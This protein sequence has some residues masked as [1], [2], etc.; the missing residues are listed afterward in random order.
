MDERKSLADANK[1]DDSK[2]DENS[3]MPQEEASEQEIENLKE[4]IEK[5]KQEQNKILAA[6][7]KEGKL[8]HSDI[9]K[10]QKLEKHDSEIVQKVNELKEQTKQEA[11]EAHVPPQKQGKGSRFAK[12]ITKLK[13]FRFG[14]IK[15]KLDHYWFEYSRVIH[16][17]RKPTRKEYRELAIM[18]IVGT[19]IIG[20]IGFIVQMIIQFI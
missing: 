14:G 2:K 10:L 20:G 12:F 9:S 8:E 17:A 6:E 15:S 1:S 19:L 7:K 18:V 3:R 5:L 11:K 4:E 13:S 16:L